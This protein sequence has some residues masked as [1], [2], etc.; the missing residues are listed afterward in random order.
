MCSF[1]NKLNYI[2]GIGLSNSIN[3]SHFIIALTDINTKIL[4]DFK[5]LK[6]YKRDY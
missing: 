5:R 2:K 4:T 6:N 3:I 1:N